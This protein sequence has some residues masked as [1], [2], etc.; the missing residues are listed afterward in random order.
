MRKYLELFTEN[1]PADIANKLVSSNWPYVGYSMTE[2]RVIHAAIPEPEEPDPAAGYVDL[3]LSVMWAECNLGASSPEEFGNYYG[4]G[5]VEGY[6]EGEPLS[7]GNYFNNDISYSKTYDAV[8]VSKQ[9]DIYM[10]LVHYRMPTA[11]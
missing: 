4:W 9:D 3:G 7:T 11:E 5:D 1:F 10:D 6:S 2:D 8:T